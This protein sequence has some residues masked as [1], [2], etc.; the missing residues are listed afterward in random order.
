MDKEIQNCPNNHGPMLL[1]KVEK[2][3]IFRDEN[4]TF[5]VESFV[6]EKCE[7][8]VATIE[9]TA[10]VQNAI[11]DAYR[12]KVGLLTGA[13]IR[14]QREKLNLSQKNLAKRAGVGIASIKR[15]ENGIIQ[16]K[17]MNSAL[18]TAF[19]NTKIGNIYTGNR[20]LSIHRIKLVIKEF[21]SELGLKFLEEG[22][23]MLFDAKYLWYADMLS[24]HKLGK[25]L[26]GATYAALPHGPQL[27][28]Y[29]ELIDDIRKADES[30]ASPLTPEEK[31]II[32]RI[33]LT[34][35]TKQSIINACHNEEVWKNKTIGTIIPYSDS[36]KLTQIQL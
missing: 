33:A 13:D 12:R 10:A 14:E 4:I 32:I 1:K 5:Q 17:S 19:Q 15:W 18:K 28:N 9:Q 2:N 24:Y 20:V 16:T 3:M 23:R 29:K 27:N 25:S 6:C 21:E 7:L 22:D 36:S 8:E 26:T 31:K 11:S 35:P 34:F 30:Q